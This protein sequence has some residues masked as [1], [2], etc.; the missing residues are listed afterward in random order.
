MGYAQ[1]NITLL[2]DNLC[3]PRVLPW[4]VS[5]SLEGSG[6]QHYIYNEDF[7]DKAPKHHESDG[8]LCVDKSGNGFSEIRL[9]RPDD[10]HF[11]K[12]Y[13]G[14]ND[15]YGIYSLYERKTKKYSLYINAIGK[16]Q[17]TAVWDPQ[18]LLSIVTER[19]DDLFATVAV[20]PD[21]KKAA[22]SVILATRKGNMKGS[23]VMVLGDGGEKLWESSF[24][25][26]F[27]N[28]T[29]IMPDMV[30]SNDGTVYIAA[31]SYA[32][33]TRKSRDN[34]TFHLYTLT[35]NNTSVAEQKIDF[36][37]IINGKLLIKRDGN[38]VM[39]GYFNNNLNERAQGYFLLTC[40]VKTDAVTN[41][42]FQKFPGE[43]Y[44]DTKI[45]LG[46]LKGD[47]M[48][49]FVEDLYEFSNGTVAMLGEQREV[50]SRT[51]SSGNGM[52]TTYYHFHAKNILVTFADTEGNLVKFDM[53]KKYQVVGPSA[54]YLRLQQLRG[55]GYSYRSFMHNDKIQ[56]LFADAL[57]NYTGKTD[58]ICK[59]TAQAKHCSALC[60]IDANQ[61]ITNPEMIIDP[62][63]HKTRMVS[64]L[65]IDG[66]G[67][68]LIN[69]AKKAGQI[70][71]LSYSF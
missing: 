17:S 59:S 12:F 10:Y 65:F 25:P 69:A 7:Y 22:L 51:V 19:R 16:E 56:I 13:E 31:V 44:S 48:S 4:L 15:L 14:E 45:T 36:G 71:K 68:L 50:M 1:D 64:P 18:E 35:D 62:K 27:T 37:Y 34:E 67:L 42:S 66:D 52:S 2:R 3:K 24:D 41:I 39:G 30:L 60:T 38:V 33:E 43:Y 49:V 9:D 28:P 53:I 54:I 6:D 58:V 40:N 32:N 63:V 46:S 11:I 26:E 61:N 55:Y 29:F 20:S 21:G 47:K 70:S 8:I 57:D 23:A 5:A